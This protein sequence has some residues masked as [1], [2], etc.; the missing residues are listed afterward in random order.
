M[1]LRNALAALFTVDMPATLV[2]DFPTVSALSR[3]IGQQIAAGEQPET[4]T[5]IVRQ[6]G[7]VSAGLGNPTTTSIVGVG[8]KY[9]E[10]H[11][12]RLVTSSSLKWAK[13]RRPQGR[14]CTRRAGWVL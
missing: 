14:T 7:L 1:E 10:S 5:C 13:L 11:G 8:C 6:E 9:P 4:D 3:Y 12:G 2:F